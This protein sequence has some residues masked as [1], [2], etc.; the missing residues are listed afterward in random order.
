MSWTKGNLTGNVSKNMYFQTL[1]MLM[2]LNLMELIVKVLG[3]LIFCDKRE[4]FI[5]LS[6]F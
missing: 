5:L 4:I 1:T 6:T 2:K 3:G